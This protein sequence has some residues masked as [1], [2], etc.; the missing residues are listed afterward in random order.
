[1]SK[2]FS[3]LLS[4]SLLFPAPAILASGGQGGAAPVVFT[5]SPQPVPFKLANEE[6]EEAVATLTLVEAHADDSLSGLLIVS[7]T[8]GRRRSLA[9]KLGVDW[10]SLPSTLA[11][12]EVRARWAKGTACPELRLAFEALEASYGGQTLRFPPFV[13]RIQETS[14][15]LP[16]LLCGWTRQI[17]A[18][19]PRRGFVMAINRLLMKEN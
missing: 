3:S 7:I 11:R 12:R 2:Y 9:Q 19:R 16:Q 18:R 17:N 13:L 1:M 14:E 10:Q 5:T 6:R 8:E 15:T 4:L